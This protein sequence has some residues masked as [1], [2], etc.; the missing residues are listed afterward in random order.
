MQEDTEEIEHVVMW[1]ADYLHLSHK[2]PAHS[3]RLLS[4]SNVTEGKCH[5]HSEG[6]TLP[7]LAGLQV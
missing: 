5:T 4:L 2:S 3:Q 1:K 6:R 7:E